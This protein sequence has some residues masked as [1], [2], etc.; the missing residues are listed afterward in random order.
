MGVVCRE[1]RNISHMPLGGIVISNNASV[2]EGW[3]VATILA[4]CKTS[5]P[6]LSSLC[7]ALWTRTKI[8]LKKGNSSVAPFF[9]VA[10]IPL[11]RV[12]ELVKWE[13]PVRTSCHITTTLCRRIVS[14]S[15]LSSSVRHPLASS[16]PTDELPSLYQI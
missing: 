6:N 2:F 10:A 8:R 12:L 11:D 9:N 15:G 14:C 7:Y 16:N 4:A 5:R 1:S 13:T 3:T